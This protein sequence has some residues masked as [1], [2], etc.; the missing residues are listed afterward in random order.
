MS[1][2]WNAT[3]GRRVVFWR[4]GRTEWNLV[5]RFQGATDVPLDAVGV[6]QARAAAP[7]LARLAPARIVSSDLGRAMAT[8][9]TLGDLVGVDPVPEPDL[10]E[11]NGGV[12]QGLTREEILA[13]H[14]ELFLAWI[15]GHDVR[16]PGGE[17]RSEVV[18]RVVGA[19]H[20]HLEDL[21]PG[22][23]MVVVSH[24]GAIRGGIGG[25]LGLAPEQWTALGV[26][27]NCAWSV[28]SQ[29]DLPG[30]PGGAPV[31]RWRLEEYNATST[32]VPA[33]GAD[34]A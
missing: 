32:P 10:R 5:S 3:P 4:H 29:L 25:L 14:R 18:G 11:T 16:P 8:A 28:L 34:D 7:V 20:R 17:V 24:G 31:T 9:R 19:V 27:A 26:I 15:A 12:W 13:E 30:E 23:T 1:R 33:L 22:G 2:G 6:A 21:E